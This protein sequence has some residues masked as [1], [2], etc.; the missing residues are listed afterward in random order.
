MD[1]HLSTTEIT[2]R[3]RVGGLEGGKVESV[4]RKESGSI[5]MVFFIVINRYAFF[6]YVEISNEISVMSFT[7]ESRN[8]YQSFT[9]K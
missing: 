3:R 1:T 2:N 9:L 4:A 8:D 5:K 6:F 7:L